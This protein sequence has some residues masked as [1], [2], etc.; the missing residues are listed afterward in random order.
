MLIKLTHHIPNRQSTDVYVVDFVRDPENVLQAIDALLANDLPSRLS[1]NPNSYGTIICDGQ[2]T[3]VQLVS[4]N[5]IVVGAANG[6]LSPAGTIRRRL[7]PPLRRFGPC[8]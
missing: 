2:E 1:Q 8:A 6:E 3:P 7:L 5:K 4:A